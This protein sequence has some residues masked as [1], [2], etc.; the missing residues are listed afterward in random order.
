MRPTNDAI[1]QLLSSDRVSVT[2]FDDEVETPIPN[3]P[4]EDKGRIVYMIRDVQP[5]NSTAL[6]AGWKEG[7]AG[8]QEPA[9]GRLE[10]GAA[11]L[12]RYCKRGVDAASTPSTRRI[13]GGPANRI[14][15]RHGGLVW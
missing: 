10:P 15:D 13:N 5:G 8:K 3:T 2:I 9:R 12:G 7:D 1:Q 11:A 14:P 4:A 6:H